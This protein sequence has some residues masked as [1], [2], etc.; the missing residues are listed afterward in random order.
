MTMFVEL[1]LAGLVIGTFIGVSG[2]GGGSIMTPVLMLLLGVNP[3][4]AVGTDLLY[5]VPTKIFGALLHSRQRTMDWRVIKGL[6]WGGIPGVVLG[7]ALLYV[8]R[9]TMD[10]T[11]LNALVKRSV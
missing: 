4:V 1:V 5:S 8:L 3:L 2:V 6:L 9:H 7:V 10:V 11:T